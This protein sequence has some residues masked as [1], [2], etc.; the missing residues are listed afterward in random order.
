LLTVIMQSKLEK[1]EFGD[2]IQY[3]IGI[4][5]RHSSC[6]GSILTQ[7]FVKKLG[8]DLD[9]GK[10]IY[11]D[12]QTAIVLANNP[13]HHTRTRHGYRVYCFTIRQQITIASFFYCIEDRSQVVIECRQI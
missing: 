5:C 1:A 3:G 6:N 7:Q 11:V 9:N 12:N 10:V 13:E 4:Y 8:R 2:I